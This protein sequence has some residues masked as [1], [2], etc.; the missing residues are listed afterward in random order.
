MPH[1][2]V[3]LETPIDR[4]FRVEQVA[5]MFD[6]PIEKRLEHRLTAEVPGLEEEWTVGAIVG[7]SGSGK[8]TLARAAFGRA[9]HE[10]REWPEGRAIIDVLGESESGR[11]REWETGR[12]GDKESGRVSIKEVARV[13]AAVGLGSV[14]TWLKPYWMLSTGERFRAELA[15]A[16]L[17]SAERGTRSTE[18]KE[19]DRNREWRAEIAAGND[20]GRASTGVLS[21]E[22]SVLGSNAR[23]A[24]VLVFDEF[25]SSLDRTVA[26]TVSAALARLLRRDKHLRFVAVT[27]HTD[28]LPWLAPDWVVELGTL[29][30]P[31]ATLSRRERDCNPGPRMTLR[32]ERVPQAMWGRFAP[33]HYLAGGL[34]ASATCYGAWLDDSPVTERHG[35]RSLQGPVAFC[36]VVAALGWRG[37]KRITRLVVLPEFQGLGI[38]SQLM[39]KVAAIESEAEPRGSAASRQTWDREGKSE[40]GCRVTITASH[41]VILEHCSR[42][43][44][45]RFLGIKKNGSTRQRFGGREIRCSSGRAVASFEFVGEG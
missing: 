34:A 15:R 4:T 38:G 18:L 25:T 36:A 27:C 43:P 33:H 32:V 24:R 3:Q 23:S 19:A 8:T 42:S 44:R 12:Q 5:G 29:T 20:D 1:V 6:L 31:S 16:V 11:E 10:P 2:S 39:E 7:P 45:W 17:A 28:I 21:T 40:R 13:L 22:Y 41:P 26:R 14:P 9:V 37:T 35:G 30:R